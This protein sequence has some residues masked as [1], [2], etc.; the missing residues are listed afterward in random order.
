M[1][2]IEDDIA[3]RDLGRWPRPNEVGWIPCDHGMSCTTLAQASN[4]AMTSVMKSAEVRTRGAAEM[5]AMATGLW[6]AL[7]TTSCSVRGGIRRPF[8]QSRLRHILPQPLEH[9][10][11]HHGQ[12]KENANPSRPAPSPT[13]QAIRPIHHSALIQSKNSG[14]RQGS[15][16]RTRRPRKETV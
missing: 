14:L 10:R 6:E 11:E 9:S 12:G 15:R 5:A 8:R 1:K 4:G 3:E 16:V 7:G 2:L 13:G